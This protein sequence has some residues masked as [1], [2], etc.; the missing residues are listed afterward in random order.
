[1]HVHIEVAPHVVG[2]FCRVSGRYETG[3]IMGRDENEVL[4]ARFEEHLV[5]TQL[6]PAT[7]VNYMADLR[8]LLRWG[9]EQVGSDF[10][11]T[12]LT[13]EDIRAYRAYVF[14]D[15]GCAAAT[16]NRQLQT[17]RKFCAFTTRAGLTDANP[18]ADIALVQGGDSEATPAPLTEEQVAALIKASASG[19]PSLARRDTVILM[20][21]LHTGLRV[22]EL[23]E[24][25]RDDVQFDY[26]GIHLVVRAPARRGRAQPPFGSESQP[27]ETRNIPLEGEARQ[28][29]FDYLSVRPQIEGEDHLFLSREGRPLSVRSVQR[30]VSVLGRSAGVAG[31]SPQAL[32]RTY[33]NHLLATTGNLALVA[34]RLGQQ[35]LA[36]AAQYVK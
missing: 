16:V 7:V 20:L 34:E 5:L 28:V 27:G 12:D 10:S 29:L 14:E 24:L 36:A 2:A 19:Q 30:I 22:N 8:A 3:E 21:L 23:V 33:A 4:L 11:L 17:L 32:R 1:M 18:A 31:V 35:D 9:E 13:A 26:P 6:S 15:K 25:H